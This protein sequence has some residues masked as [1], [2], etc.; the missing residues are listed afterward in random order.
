[1]NLESSTYENRLDMAISKPES[2]GMPESIKPLAIYLKQNYYPCDDNNINVMYRT[3]HDFVTLF[4]DM[5][6]LTENDV[7]K[8]FLYLGYRMSNVFNPCWCLM[9]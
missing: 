1:M 2:L 6:N 9:P 7:A 4:S 8:L 5:V 3:S